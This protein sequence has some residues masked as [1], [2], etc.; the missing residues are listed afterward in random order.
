MIASGNTTPMG[1][2]SNAPMGQLWRVSVAQTNDLKS[3]KTASLS[4]CVVVDHVHF[5]DY[6]KRPAENKALIAEYTVCPVLVSASF[7]TEVTSLHKQKSVGRN[8]NLPI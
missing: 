4:V 3:V 8:K 6:Y 7:L 2:Y 1:P 5:F